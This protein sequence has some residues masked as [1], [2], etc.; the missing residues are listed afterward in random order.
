MDSSVNGTSAMISEL[1]SGLWAGSRLPGL[2]N[3]SRSA[4]LERLPSP[5][6]LF[7][8]GGSSGSPRCVRIFRI[9]PG[10]RTGSPQQPAAMR[11]QIEAELAAGP[12]GGRTQPCLTVSMSSRTFSTGVWGRMPWPRLASRSRN[13]SGGNSTT[14]LAPGRVDFSAPA[15]S[16]SVGG[17]NGDTVPGQRGARSHGRGAGNVRA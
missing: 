10:S 7:S 12:S 16:D 6:G 4:C 1:T 15:G 11:D 8:G 13:S 9:R 5:G 2:E 3:G 14:P 17:P